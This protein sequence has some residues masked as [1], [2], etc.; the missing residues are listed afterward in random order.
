[1]LWDSLIALGN[2]LSTDI[3]IC[4]IEDCLNTAMFEMGSSTYLLWLKK[5]SWL[6]AEAM[7]LKQTK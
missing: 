7:K 4:F 3:S 1:M 2:Q 6:A 5:E